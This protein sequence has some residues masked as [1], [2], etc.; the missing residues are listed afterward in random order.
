MP[1][2]MGW[3][4]EG[5]PKYILSDNGPQFISQLT[6]QV[7]KLLGIWKHF[8]LLYHTMPNSL[9]DGI[10]RVL[11]TILGRVRTEHPKDWNL[12]LQPTPFGIRKEKEKDN[13]GFSTLIQEKISILFTSLQIYLKGSSP[14]SLKWMSFL[15]VLQMF[16]IMLNSSH[17]HTHL[18]IISI[19]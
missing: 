7:A 6:A 15:K 10:N 17:I 2:G 1:H 19:M 11:N 4:R 16:L 5:Y 9:C 14:L 3:R 12:Y 13:T 8:L 18:L